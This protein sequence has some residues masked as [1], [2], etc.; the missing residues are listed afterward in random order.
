MLPHLAALARDEVAMP[1]QHGLWTHREHLPSR[2]RDQAAG[3]GQQHPV[4]GL[5]ADLA[6]LA[7]EHFS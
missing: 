7:P 5:E 3:G 6:D 2:L 1:P 4:M